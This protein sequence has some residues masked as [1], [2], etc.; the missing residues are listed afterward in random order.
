MRYAEGNIPKD[1]LAMH[2]SDDMLIITSIIA[3]F[4]ALALIYLGRQ[5]KQLYMWTWGIG[6]ALFSIFLGV[7]ISFDWKPLTSF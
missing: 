6:L 3:F 5:G 2:A 4:I 1:Q 7:S